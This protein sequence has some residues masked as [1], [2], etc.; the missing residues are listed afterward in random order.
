MAEGGGGAWL[1]RKL[2]T[3]ASAWLSAETF[4]ITFYNCFLGVQT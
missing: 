4:D 2:L 1:Q 3:S